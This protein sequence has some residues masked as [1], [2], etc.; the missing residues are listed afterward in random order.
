MAREALR[1]SL[2]VMSGKLVGKRVRLEGLLLIGR[3]PAADIVLLEEDVSWHHAR[4]EDRGDAYVL[5]DLGS[6]NGSHVNGARM[7]EHVLSRNDRIQIGSTMARFEI[8]DPVEHAFYEHV[9]RLL[10]E[11]D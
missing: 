6:T 10:E 4:I 9:E 7:T 5:I 8:H 1:P 2:V 3:D 11:D